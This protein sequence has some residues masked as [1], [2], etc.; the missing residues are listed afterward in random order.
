MIAVDYIYYKDEY[1]GIVDEASFNKYIRQ[2]NITVDSYCF[3]RL[4]KAVESDFTE[5]EL[6]KIKDCLCAVTEI[7]CS[8]VDSSG[9]VTSSKKESETVGPWSIKFSQSSGYSSIDAEIHAKVKIYLSGLSIT[10][11]WI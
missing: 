8:H 11:S 3:N 2:A 4:E 5:F 9:F 7:Y 1:G 6:Q 10:C